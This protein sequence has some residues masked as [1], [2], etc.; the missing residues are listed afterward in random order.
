L[1]FFFT[2][3]T[4]TAETA[5]PLPVMQTMPPIPLQ[6]SHTDFP[7]ASAAAPP[8]PAAFVTEE[9]GVLHFYSRESSP[10]IPLSKEL[11]GVARI[12]SAAK[13][14]VLYVSGNRGQSWVRTQKRA[15]PAKSFQFE[16]AN[17]GEYWLIFQAEE[18]DARGQA[19]AP[20]AAPHLIATIDRV[21]PVVKELVSLPAEAGLP[22]DVVWQVEDRSPLAEV[23]VVAREV[24]G[25][26]TLSPSEVATANFG[27]V[28]FASAPAGQ[29]A[30]NLAFRDAAGNVTTRRL[31]V[32]VK[33]AAVPLSRPTPADPKSGAVLEPPGQVRVREDVSVIAS[34]TLSIGYN[35]DKDHPPSRVGLW[36]TH[37]GGR[38]W[39]LDQVA[40]TLSGT[41]ICGV[42][43]DGAYGFRVHRELGDQVWGSPKNGDV[44]ER[45]IIVDTVPPKVDWLAPLG[46]VT[47]DPPGR[48]PAK[49]TGVAALKWKITEDYPAEHPVLL[50]YRLFG[51]T[52]WMPLVGP[53]ADSGAYA[54]TLPADL[55]GPIEVR[56]TA[57]DRAAHATVAMLPLE[58]VPGARP[59]L[60]AMTGAPA[61]AEAARDAKAEARRAYAMATLARMQENWTGAEEQLTRATA[62]DPDYGRAW[63]DLGGV[64]VHDGR[65][66][67][68]VDAYRKATQVLPDSAN[69]KLGLARALANR[70]DQ[71]GAIGILDTLVKQT[72]DDGDAWL[73]QGDTLW[74]TGDKARAR[75]AWLKALSLGGGQGANL[76]AIQ[77]RLQLKD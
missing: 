57:R 50:D 10:E 3:V 62:L 7:A 20:D 8:A 76:A 23:K 56:L 75:Q 48:L 74:K 51:K 58:V 69:A 26:R 55:T 47:A 42:E 9:N 68:A 73:L 65:W 5:A 15:M 45:E 63:T 6:G 30:I 72:P 59:P 33:E 17:D 41:F 12:D 66:E 1:F 77:Q 44:P 71:A 18:V 70:G 2:T 38:T 14:V 40:A 37:D 36:V 34:R 13:A 39:R 16:A 29:W 49:V 35:W 11:L 19:P 52:A 22:L 46:D 53:L 43:E 67:P 61:S 25:D 21:A 54:W 28:R 27:R 24:L 32:A 31:E 60:S 64:Y 4:V